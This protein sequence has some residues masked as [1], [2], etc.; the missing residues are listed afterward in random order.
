MSERL[1][2]RL[3]RV[4]LAE[5]RDGDVVHIVTGDEDLETYSYD[6][7]VTR[8]GEHPVGI[9]K[10]YAPIT[11]GLVS[12]PVEFML[13][14]TGRW[15]TRDENPLQKQE[16]VLSSCF[17]SLLVGGFVVGSA[18]ESPNDRAVFSDPVLSLEV[19]KS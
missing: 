13:Q 6:F 8:S 18:P 5:L 11:G 15:T 4:V 19:R 14:G 3:D 10:S 12:D 9:I 1:L 17:D 16:L 2:E 7:V